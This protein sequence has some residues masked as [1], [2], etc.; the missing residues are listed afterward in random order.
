MTEF[1]EIISSKFK[2]VT[3]FSFELLICRLFLLQYVNQHEQKT[4]KTTLP[5]TDPRPSNCAMDA[6]LCF[7]IYGEYAALIL[8]SSFGWCS[9]FEHH[10]LVLVGR[11]RQ[12]RDNIRKHFGQFERMYRVPTQ[13]CV[14]LCS[15]DIRLMNISIY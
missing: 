8:Y 14:F 9:G 15:S 12:S 11:I 4:S 10:F 6:L 3:Q 1:L 5:E 2:Y 7:T 13:K